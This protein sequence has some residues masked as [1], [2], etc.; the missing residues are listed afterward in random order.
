MSA[1]QAVAPRPSAVTVEAPPAPASPPPPT[2]SVVTLALPLVVL[3]FAVVHVFLA[4]RSW[5]RGHKLLF[6]V[7][8][9]APLAWWAGAFLPP[10][11]DGKM[12]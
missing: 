10:P 6:A 2:G 7:G 8:F 11:R 3:L 5:K 12:I 1:L 4:I 9:I